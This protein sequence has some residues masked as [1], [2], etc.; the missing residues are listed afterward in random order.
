M[1]TKKSKQLVI[2]EAIQQEKGNWMKLNTPTKLKIYKK[3]YA[4]K[5]LIQGLVK[6]LSCNY[7]I[8]SK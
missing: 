7:Q 6:L 8:Q 2:Q 4:S 5:K 1:Q 3:K